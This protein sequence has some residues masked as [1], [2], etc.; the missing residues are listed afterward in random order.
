MI[1]NTTPLGMPP[2]ENKNPLEA[3]IEF[4]NLEILIDIG[5]SK[6]ESILMKRYKDV[7]IVNGLGMLIAQGIESFN[8]WTESKLIFSELY[9]E[10]KELLEEEIY[11]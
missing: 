11:D 5:Y 2:Y 10:I 9:R 8:L 7:E 3:D 1:V 6:R 4:K